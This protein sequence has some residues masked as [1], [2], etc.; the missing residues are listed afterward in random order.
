[1]IIE[2]NASSILRTSWS[3]Y[4]HNIRSFWLP[5][6][7][8]QLPAA[9][10]LFGL[11]TWQSHNTS[12]GTAILTTGLGFLLTCVAWQASTL[13]L[14]NKITTVFQAQGYSIPSGSLTGKT[15]ITVTLLLAY[16]LLTGAGLLLFM[17]PGAVCALWLALILPILFFEKPN[18]IKTICTQSK[19]KVTHNLRAVLL[20]S[21][22]IFAL[23]ILLHTPAAFLAYITV[24]P[25]SPLEGTSTRITHHIITAIV[26]TLL[27]PYHAL[28]TVLLYTAIN[29]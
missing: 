25:I 8:I 15:A 21:L 29:K 11:Q 3:V 19:T 1:M 9:L 2:A 10:L 17:L 26:Y 18:N 20:V 4:Q 5:V 28:T 7:L 14:F 24:G 13:L 27:I 22:T 6:I 12:L 23:G 16:T